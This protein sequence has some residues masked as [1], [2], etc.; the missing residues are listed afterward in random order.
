[1]IEG[2][3]IW[4]LLIAGAVFVLLV[5]L[6]LDMKEEAKHSASAV[7]IPNDRLVRTVH[8]AGGETYRLKPEEALEFDIASKAEVTFW[9]AGCH[10][11][12]VNPPG[13]FEGKAEMNGLKVVLKNKKSDRLSGLITLVRDN[14][15]PGC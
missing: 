1:M 3:G 5:A 13:R 7:G 6:G 14:D 4:G 15:Y 10:F 2:K 12:T 9:G 8:F 11:I